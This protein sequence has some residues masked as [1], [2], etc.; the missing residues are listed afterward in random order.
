MCKKKHSKEYW[1]NNRRITK[2]Q[3]MTV[4][5]PGEMKFKRTAVKN[6]HKNP[7]YSLNLLIGK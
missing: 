5:K 2:R 6:L 4:Q 1:K 7:G 3:D